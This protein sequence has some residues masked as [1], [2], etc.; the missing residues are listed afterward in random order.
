M[1]LK[2]KKK[3]L[4]NKV[5]NEKL[6]EIDTFARNLISER[7]GHCRT[8]ISYCYQPANSMQNIV[9]KMNIDEIE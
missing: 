9:E 3:T 6:K 5:T 2:R 1:Q 4:E 7:A 8:S